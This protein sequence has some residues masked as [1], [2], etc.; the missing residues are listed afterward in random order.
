MK[1]IKL[2]DTGW[3]GWCGGRLYEHN[4]NEDADA[5]LQQKAKETGTGAAILTAYNCL[6]GWG[7]TSAQ[8]K[9]GPY[10]WP[11]FIESDRFN[12]AGKKWVETRVKI[13]DS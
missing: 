12:A 3:A 2:D 13:A 4:G 6:Y 11:F 10:F 7:Y 8:Y 5:A 9:D 1:S